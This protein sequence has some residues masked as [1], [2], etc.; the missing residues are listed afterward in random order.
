MTDLT[1]LSA[2]KLEALY[3][4]RSEASSVNCRKFIEAG[5]GMERPTQIRTQTDALS[6][7]YVAVNEAFFAVV[8][9]MDARKRYHG[10]SKP[11]KRPVWA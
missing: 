10:S 8:A 1:K 4:K 6:L 7:E 11:I 2:A 5:R 9:E 3:A